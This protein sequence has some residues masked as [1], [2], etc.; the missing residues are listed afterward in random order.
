MPLSSSFL[1][2]QPNE[3]SQGVLKKK[4]KVNKSYNLQA[5]KLVTKKWPKQ[6]RKENV[7]CWLLLVTVPQWVHRKG[8]RK[9]KDYIGMSAHGNSFPWIFNIH[10][11]CGQDTVHH[12]M[13]KWH[14][15]FQD[16][17]QSAPSTQPGLRPSCRSRGGPK[18][19]RTPFGTSQDTALDRHDSSNYC[20]Y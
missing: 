17:K 19:S 5:W 2:R 20:Y 3:L 11:T 12:P 16:Q 18:H 4:K 14:S 1:S 7:C 15:W 8:E 13:Q 6:S 9:L 10:L